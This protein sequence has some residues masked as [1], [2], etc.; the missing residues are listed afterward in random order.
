M[1]FPHI[2][3][4]VLVSLIATG[5]H[6]QALTPEMKAKV[7]IKIRQLQAFSTAPEVV[8]AV[9]AHNVAPAPEAAGMTNDKWKTLSL[10][11]PVVRSFTKNPLGQYLKA[12]KDEQISECFVSGADGTKVAFLSK[13]TNWSH[14]DKDKHKVPMTG[15]TWIGPVE[16]DES[17]GQ[18]Q[19]QVGLPV[20]DGGK[21]IGSIVIGLGI[22][23]LK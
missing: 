17:S 16:V 3:H 6:G 12:K 10:L 14:R 13:P 11:D 5:V 2:Q 22:S 23:K 8:S 21:P 20:L 9:K 19:V 1:R 4:A 18:Q 7:D 15:K